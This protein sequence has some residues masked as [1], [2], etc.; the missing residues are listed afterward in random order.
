MNSF[1][2]EQ[3]H[4]WPL[5]AQNF[6][7]LER[8]VTRTLTVDGFPVRLQHNP[9][10]IQSTGAKVSPE[11]ISKRPCFLCAPNRPEQQ[12]ATPFSASRDYEIL[13]NPFPIAPEHFTVA[14]TEH[15]HQDLI[16]IADMEAFVKK[17]PD[18]AAFY[19]GSKSGASAPDHLHFQAC[20]KDFLQEIIAHVSDCKVLI[21][22]T[23]GAQI[24]ALPELPMQAIYFV[25]ETVTPEVRFW[26]DNVLP[27]AEGGLTPDQGMRNLVMWQHEGQLHLLFFPRAKHRPDCFFA[28]GDAQRLIS[29]GALD[30][31]GVLILPRPEDY[32]RLTAADVRRVYDEVSFYY[33]DSPYFSHALTL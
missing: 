6:N 12:R 16:E 20:N 23:P 24:F 30:M 14:A 22:G 17:Y 15:L 32:D 7:A 13:V 29:P 25:A 9:G 8:V 31:A 10:R 33:K 5:A 21:K 3:L 19:N 28:E 11:A 18:Y 26:T 27:A 1:L 4:D 2:R